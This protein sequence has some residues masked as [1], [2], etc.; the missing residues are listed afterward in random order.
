MLLNLKVQMS[1]GSLLVE[2]KQISTTKKCRLIVKQR[3]ASWDS[4]PFLNQYTMLL[5]VVFEIFVSSCLFIIPENP[6]RRE[7]N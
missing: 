4:Y 7:G 3:I 2:Q 1:L 6:F 5:Y